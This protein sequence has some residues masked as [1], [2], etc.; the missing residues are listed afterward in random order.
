MNRLMICLNYRLATI[1]VVVF[2]VSPT[3]GDERVSFRRD[4]RPI[5]ADKC[6]HCHGPDAEQR[7]AGL[8]LDVPESA[9][10]AAES[11]DFA[12][13]PGQSAA[14]ALM[15]RVTH[16]DPE[17]RMPPAD[18]GKELS[19][20]EI[21]LVRRWIDEGASFEKHWSLMPILRPPIPSVADRAWPLSPLD[22]FV[23]ARLEL[24]GIRPSEPA[25]RRT[26]V[27]R[28]TLDLTGLPPTIEEVATFVED[29]SPQ[30]YEKL[31]DRLLKSPGYAEHMARFWLDVVR[32]GDTHGLHLDNYR[33]I[34]PYRD[35]VISAFDSNMPFDQFTIEQLAG[36]LLPEP[37]L[38]QLVATGYNRCHI[39]TNEG[40]AI[41]EE[42]YVRNVVDRVSTT[43]TVFMGLTLGCAQCHDH[44]FDPVTQKEFYQLFA[45]F[46][47]LDGSPLD[48]NAA[49]PAPVVKVPTMDQK[50]WLDELHRR[51]Q[52][53]SE[54]FD[55][56]W[57]EIDERQRAWEAE[58]SGNDKNVWTVLDPL[59]F[60]STAGATLR[61]L[62]DLSVL[63]EGENPAQDTYEVVVHT[64]Q[65]PIRSLRLETLTHESLPHTGPG[66][67][68]NGNFVL[69]EI[70]VQAVSISDPA[71][72]QALKFL[73]AEADHE[74]QGYPA[75]KVIDGNAGS[76][77]GWA[78]EGAV[79]HEDRRL[80]LTSAEEIGYP[81]GTELRIRLLCNTTHAQHA[82]GRFRFAAGSLDANISSLLAV[83]AGQRTPEQRKQ[84]QD[85]FRRQHTDEGRSVADELDALRLGSDEIEKQ[86]ATT[87]VMKERPEPRV[88]YFLQRGHYEAKG[89][90]VE[91]AT[92]TALPPMDDRLPRNRLGLAQWLMDPRH[93]LT[94]R[95][96][97]NR[98]WQQVFGRGITETS[99]DLGSQGA[100]PTHPVL[101][102]WLAIEWM[103]D[104]WDVKRLMKRLIM[105]ATYQ[106]SSRTRPEL[107]ERDPYNTLLARGPRYRLDA[108]MLRDQ[109]LSV[110]GLLVQQVGG[111]SVKPPQPDG[112]WHAVGYSNSNTVRFV[113]DAGADRVYRRSL[114]TFWKRT[115]PPPQMAIFDAPTREACTVRRERTNTPLQAL[116]TMNE[117]Q[118]LE[119]ARQLAQNAMR[120]AEASPGDRAQY[121]FLRATARLPNPTELD[122]LVQNFHDHRDHYRQHRKAAN[123]LVRSAG[124][125]ADVELPIDELAAWT[126]VGN[127]ILNL[128]EVLSKS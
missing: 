86:M 70:E 28:V 84:I 23:L 35:W 16:E 106:Q 120:E 102:D 29:E 78:P 99:E 97:V 42:W 25:D 27:R 111:P 76:N 83:G 10:T 51:E 24:E 61:K 53:L 110:S 127:L 20:A 74:Q 50:R 52:A 3:F 118:C 4:I 103:E 71:E 114:Y 54:R 104:S 124:L 19:Q 81:G 41:Q 119:A 15:A 69:G 33:E 36:D 46:N 48:G 95:V 1:T 72:P 49:D 26:L 67:A 108:E 45:F 101:L 109:V 59:K 40:G 89:D 57:P 128:D 112:L 6:F 38:E 87:L 82:I 32:Y 105:S 14:S 60:E 63:A 100:T 123:S 30:A 5:L 122:T 90:P 21:E 65:Y 126:M 9:T 43:G 55:Q 107:R 96:A 39:S 31:V 77:E 62:D 113:A 64:D 80:I 98:I 37:T 44:K 47:N 68:G 73:R 125:T 17:L 12:I 2:L 75:A 66:R 34:W 116:M 22:H 93:P 115:S 117:V 13:V 92:P 88:A 8:R 7:Q 58:R 121:I 85:H 56:P 11:G 94:A 91:R 79:R 18:T